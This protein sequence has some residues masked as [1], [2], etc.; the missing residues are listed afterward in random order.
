MTN[1]I[2]QGLTRNPEIGNTSVWVFPNIW[3]LGQV[4]DTK[5]NTNASNEI[6]LNAAKCQVLN[7]KCKITAFTVSELLWKN[8]KEGG[9]GIKITPHQSP[10]PD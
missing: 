8:Q 10:H 2:Y 6:L 3:R 9:G 1:F 4:S 5:F 7:Y